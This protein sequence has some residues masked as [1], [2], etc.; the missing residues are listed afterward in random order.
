MIITSK[1]FDNMTSVSQKIS[2][3]IIGVGLIGPRHARTVVDSPEAELFAIVDPLPKS[4]SLAEE[5]GAQYFK[6][7]QN[8]VGNPNKPDAA[9]V[10]TPNH[11]HVLVAKELAAAGIHV[12]VEK[13]ISTD[14][15]SGKDLI[16]FAKD[17]GIKLL[18]GHHRRFNPY[19][20]A[21][22]K[23]ILSGSLGNIV[24]VSGLWTLCKPMEYFDAPAEWRRGQTGGVILINLIHEVDLLHHLIGPI[25]RVYAEKT[26]SRRG[27]E[28]EEGAAITFR[29]ASGAVGTFVVS[30]NVASPYNFESGT[31][32]NPLIPRTH[33]VDFYRIF[34]TSG[35]LSV[36]DM[37]KWSYAGSIK[38]WH[39]P[40]VKTNIEVSDA[41]PFELQLAHF[42][43]V[44]KGEEEPSCDGKAGLAAL[45]VCDAVKQALESGQPVDVESYM[46]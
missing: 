35:T 39:E 17:S 40:M 33:G 36:P 19:V 42:I 38:S 9:I 29:F 45:I 13:P 22:K 1:N 25:V 46:L 18:V 30:D 6:S 14:I 5:L 23:E 31:G 2:I 34:G 41:T 21:A 7:V 10:C 26:R 24:A 15:E 32:E 8:L 28:A 20:V 44:V 43:E 12:L 4:A 16:K 11:T 37:A 27:Y 3:A